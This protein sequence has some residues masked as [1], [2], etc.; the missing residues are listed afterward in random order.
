MGRKVAQR[1][2]PLPEGQTVPVGVPLP[3]R[4]RHRR[5]ER[6]RLAEDRRVGRGGQAWCC[7]AWLTVWVSDGGG[8]GGEAGVAAVDGG[9]R[10]GADRQ[11]GGGEGG[12]AAGSSVPVPRV[13]EPS[14]KVTVPVGVPAPGP[15]PSP[16]P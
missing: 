4:P 5:R 6:H 13:V 1:C 11:R 3:G 2:R 16:S 9:D 15:S 12:R 8:A 10:V 14:L 7:A